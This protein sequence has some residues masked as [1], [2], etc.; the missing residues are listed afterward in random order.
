[1]EE[2]KVNYCQGLVQT[3][4]AQGSKLVNTAKCKFYTERIALAF[5]SK[6]LQQIVSNNSNNNNGYF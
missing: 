4:Q 1:M 2:H 3:G 5:S 6:E